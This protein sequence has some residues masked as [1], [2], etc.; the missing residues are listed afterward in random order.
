MGTSLHTLSPPAG[1][2]RPR[3]RVGRGHG[4]G[5]HKTSG[6]GTKGQKAR[7]GHHGLPKPGFE[8]GQTAMARRLPKRGFNNVFRQEVSA[9][10]LGALCARFPGSTQIDVEQLK[11]AGLVPRSARIVKILGTVREGQSVPQGLTVRAHAFSRS[12]KELLE[13]A[14]GAAEVLSRGKAAAPEA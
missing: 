8:G 12:A 6:K 10:N 2:N 11:A 4:S 7:S 13:K 3:K 5:R 1:A 9:V 14:G